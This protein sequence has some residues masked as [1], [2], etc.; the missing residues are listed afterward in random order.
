MDKLCHVGVVELFVSA[1][2]N[3]HD[4]LPLFLFK[5][6]QCHPVAV[7]CR[8]SGIVVVFH[9]TNR[10]NKLQASWH[11]HKTLN[12]FF[13]CLQIEI[14][15]L[16]HSHS[17]GNIRSIVLPRNFYLP[18]FWYDIFSCHQ[19]NTFYFSFKQLGNF[20]CRLIAHN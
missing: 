13:D 18:C 8:G 5:C 15:L 1:T 14:K 16:T 19:H 3:E 11:T 17:A 7:W 9:P 10:T 4:V 6:R 12:S 20:L 2:C